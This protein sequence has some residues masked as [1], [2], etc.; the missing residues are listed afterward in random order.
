MRAA[1]KQHGL[2]RGAPG[3]ASRRRIGSEGIPS[4]VFRVTDQAETPRE[5]RA[6][7]LQ[8]ARAAEEKAQGESNLEIREQL[9]EIAVQWALLA[10]ELDRKATRH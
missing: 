4:G 8:L 7:Y 6:R 5:R 9:L 2:M 1:S 10:E 3:R